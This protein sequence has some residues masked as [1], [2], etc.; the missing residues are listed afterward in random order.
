MDF[1]VQVRPEFGLSLETFQAALRLRGALRPLA[2]VLSTAVQ[3]WRFCRV[4]SFYGVG[5][6]YTHVYARI[7]LVLCQ[8]VLRTDISIFVDETSRRP[9]L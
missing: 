8:A 9:H 5:V 1:T 7:C 2:W 3:K 4:D 6:D